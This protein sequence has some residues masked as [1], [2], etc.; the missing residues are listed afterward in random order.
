MWTGARTAAWRAAEPS[1]RPGATRWGPARGERRQVGFVICLSRTSHS[2]DTCS[3][4]REISFD[5]TEAFLWMSTSMFKEVNR[6][7]NKI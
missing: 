2:N 6:K 1:S 4:I 7:A 5:H 3:H